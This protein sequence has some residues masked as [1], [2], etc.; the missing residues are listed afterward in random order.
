MAWK[1]DWGWTSGVWYCSWFWY[2]LVLDR[3]VS[4]GFNNN[5]K[6]GMSSLWSSMLSPCCPLPCWPS[7]SCWRKA[8]FS[9]FLQLRSS[10]LSCRRGKDGSAVG[11]G[12]SLGSSGVYCAVTRAHQHAKPSHGSICGEGGDC[13]T[14]A[15]AARCWQHRAAVAGC[16]TAEKGREG[17]QGRKE[18]ILRWIK[19]LIKSYLPSL[20]CPTLDEDN[21]WDKYC[22]FEEVFSGA[23]KISFITFNCFSSTYTL[24]N[25]GWPK[26]ELNSCR[27]SQAGIEVNGQIILIRSS[28]GRSS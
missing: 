14:S 23:S 26:T 28:P 11:V 21:T 4:V 24:L 3:A 7:Q 13:R 20:L 5:V 6:L 27:S 15:E 12:L 22:V 18:R 16:H 9:L 10:F 19:K 8:C 17:P 1:Q 25:C 2:D